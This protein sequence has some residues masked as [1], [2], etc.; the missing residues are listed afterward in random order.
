MKNNRNK[1]NKKIYRIRNWSEYNKTLKCRGSITFW[2][3][4]DVC[5]KWLE[6]KKSGKPGA[7]MTYSNTAIETYLTIMALYRLPLRCAEGFLTSLF[8]LMRLNLPV[9]EYSTV[10]RRRKNLEIELPYT[11][12][13]EGIHVVIDSTGIKIYGEGEWKVRQH[14]WQRRRTWRKLHIGVDES[15]CE[16]VAGVV[17]HSEVADGSV[18]AN[19]LEQIVEP[20]KQVSL[21]GAYD[22]QSNYEKIE[23]RQARAVIPPRKNAKINQRKQHGVTPLTR[24]E[25]LR[26]IRQ[27][28]RPQWKEETGY[29]RR[30]LAETTMFRMKRIFGPTLDSRIFESQ[31]NDLFIRCRLLNKMT[32]LGRPDSYV[33]EITS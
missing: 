15:T 23:E 14:G 31:A 7:S 30:S 22:W 25:S 1:P 33:V 29:H 17:T 9:P 32:E 21:D 20:I 19:V 6:T 16:I 18:L 11:A 26:R 8:E 28:G 13:D 5:S 3:G 2:F 27:I 10:S 4:E 24:D 12:R